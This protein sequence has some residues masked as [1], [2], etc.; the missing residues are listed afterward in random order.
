MRIIP[1]KAFQDNYIWLI[2]DPS[3]RQACVV[4]PGD[5]EVVFAYLKAHQLS[6]ST[7][8]ITHHHH[9]HIGGVEALKAA[10]GAKVISSVHDKLSF[11]DLELDANDKISIFDDTYQFEVMHLP[12]HTLGHIA[13]YEANKKAL[14]CGD[15]LFR[16]GC[17]RLFEGTPKQMLASLKLLAALPAETLVYCTHEYTMSNLKFA[18]H[19]EPD[20]QAI[21]QLIEQCQSLRAQDKE[22]LPSTIASEL[23][24]N[25]FLRSAQES[26][27]LRAKALTGKN[28][29]TEEATFATIRALKDNF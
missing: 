9:D 1:I 20:N 7:I 8:L 17:G 11:S 25:P 19:I 12:G 3:S 4:D 16:A 13:Y 14:F 2:R 15:T 6:L 5:S 28:S 26:I 27:K 24:T 22:T 23:A 10:T 21:K 29:D 18:Q